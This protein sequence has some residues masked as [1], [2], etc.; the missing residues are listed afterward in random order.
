MDVPGDDSLSGSRLPLQKNRRI[1]RSHCL[2]YTQHVEPGPVRADRAKTYVA[3][4]D[5]ALER[6]VLRLELP[7]LGSALDDRNERI[8]LKRFLN[9]VERT[10]VDRGYRRLKRCLRRH[11]YHRYVGILCLRG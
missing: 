1:A 11:Q 4:P 2:G 8:V 10:V 7:R 6:F 9:V 5:L 3:F